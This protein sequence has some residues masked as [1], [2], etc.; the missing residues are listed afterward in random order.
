MADLQEL[1]E[2]LQKALPSLKGEWILGGRGYER[3]FAPAIG[4]TIQ[5]GRYWDCIWRGI[6]LELKKGNIWLDLVRYSE[7]L[8]EKTP[9]SSIEVL[10]L[11]IR[12]REQQVTDIYA[13]TTKKILKVLNLSPQ[14][15]KDLLR[16]RDEV[17]RSFNAQASLE[18]SDVRKIAEFHVQQQSLLFNSE[19]KV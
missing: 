6:Y 9:E 15:A 10:T 16:I 2:H 7:C 4:A 17:P 13:V 8:L 12:Y 19:K 3:Y 14:T 11:F 5:E 1:K 18:E